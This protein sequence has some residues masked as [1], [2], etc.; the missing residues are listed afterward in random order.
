MLLRAGERVEAARTEIGRVDALMYLDRYAEARRVGM[1]ALREFRNLDEPVRAGRLLMNLGNLEYRRDRPRAALALYREARSTLAGRTRPVDLAHVDYNIANILA[2]LGDTGESERLYGE[3]A[4]TAGESGHAML[5]LHARYAE[6]SLDMARVRYVDALQK[7]AACEAAFGRAGHERAR[8]NCLLDRAE[9]YRRLGLEGD[10]HHAA[11]QAAEGFA[12]L[13]LEMETARARFYAGIAALRSD[14]GERAASDLDYAAAA[15]RRLGNPV[16]AAAVLLRRAQSE[17]VTGGGHVGTDRLHA[18]RRTF[19]RHGMADLEA[20]T[21]LEVARRRLAERKPGPARRALD[22]VAAAPAVTGHPE[23]ASRAAHLRALWLELRG[24]ALEAAGVSVQALEGLETARRN[25]GTDELLRAHLWD[26]RRIYRDVLRLNAAVHGGRPDRLFDLVVRTD[27]AVAGDALRGRRPVLEPEAEALRERLAVL[28]AGERSALPAESP[29]TAGARSVRRAE[30]DLAEALRRARL[31]GAA[32]AAAPVANLDALQRQLRDGELWLHPVDCGERL[33]LLAVTR[34]AARL[35]TGEGLDRKIFE[36]ALRDVRFQMERIHLNPE[37]AR[38]RADSLRE[39]A[40]RALRGLAAPFLEAVPELEECRHLLLKAGSG[41]E[42]VPWGALP[43]GGDRPL[44]TRATVH[45]VPD[46]GFFLRARRRRSAPRPWTEHPALWGVAFTG[47][48]ETEREVADVAGIFPGASVHT[49]EEA[50]L[51][52]FRRTAPRASL[53]HFAGHGR[54]RHDNPLFSSLRFADGD[55][56]FLDLEAL[57]LRRPLVVLSAC[58]SGRA[59]SGFSM[60]TG[61]SRGFLRAGAE[62]MVVSHWRIGDEATRIMMRAFYRHL[63][64]ESAP[65]RALRAAARE[66]EASGAHPAV[67]AAFGVVG[68]GV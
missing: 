51:A 67:W 64:R 16:Q 53:I 33:R 3:V 4:R 43:A 42:H 1:R 54:F 13:G 14:E 47:L 17:P 8:C 19:A 6:A 55:L 23:L 49:G 59:G 26:H 7:L 25:L 29:P 50:D 44:W 66:V 34:T 10:A 45:A 52:S 28:S 15:F 39:G 24:D 62:H 30:R 22:R 36:S 31:A 38:R 58:T 11:E 2:Q 60:G 18:A 9:V 56:T 37:Y 20:E 35:G 32:K 61:L 48:P 63:A 5:E 27:V 57:R 41:L 68:A 40:G 12:A 65:G 46:L 21:A